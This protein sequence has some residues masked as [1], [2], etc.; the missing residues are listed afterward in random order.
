MKPI[1]KV[2][3]V[4]TLGIL[5]QGGIYYYLDQYMFAPT[6]DFSVAGESQKAD[7]IQ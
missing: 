2:M 3:T 5:L 4:F 1:T 6:T 7:D